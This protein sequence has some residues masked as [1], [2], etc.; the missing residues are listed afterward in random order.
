MM[1]QDSMDLNENYRE[2]MVAVIAAALRDY[3]M[4]LKEC[5]MHRTDPHRKPV[6]K[7]LTDPKNAYANCLEID[8]KTCVE[9]ME[10]NF[11]K[12]GKAMMVTDEWNEVEKV[13]RLKE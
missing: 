11:K 2:L 3:A 8:L 5:K 12:Y 6:Y 4:V 7:F 1:P 9:T 10:E 13:R